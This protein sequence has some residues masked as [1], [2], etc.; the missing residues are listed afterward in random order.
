MYVIPIINELRRLSESTET[1]A[2]LLLC[3]LGCQVLGLTIVVAKLVG[4]VLSKLG[5]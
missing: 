2:F 3:C 4:R 5:K 1:L